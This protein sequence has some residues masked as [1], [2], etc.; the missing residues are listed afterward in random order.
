MIVLY[1]DQIE[2]LQRVLEPNDIPRWYPMTHDA[3]VHAM[4][5]RLD[6]K[7]PWRAYQIYAPRPSVKKCADGPFGAPVV[8]WEVHH[9]NMHH[10]MGA[11]VVAQGQQDVSMEIT[12]AAGERWTP[13]PFSIDLLRPYQPHD[14][15]W[16]PFDFGV[17]T[18]LMPL[19]FRFE[20]TCC[21]VPI[22]G[23]AFDFFLI[24][25]IGIPHQCCPVSD[26]A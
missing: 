16:V 9:G 20:L 18:N 10:G 6:T 7:E 4:R 1:Q 2:S 19:T 5:V 3:G 21:P 13:H 26:P 17:F 25:H 12:G 23:Q 22:A 14:G 24:T 15:S 8:E 11:L